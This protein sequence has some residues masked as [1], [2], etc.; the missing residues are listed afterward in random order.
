MI[1]ALAW[2]ESTSLS[3]WVVGSLWAFPVILT[4]HAIGM[5]KLAS[6]VEL[7][8]GGSMLVVVYLAA[9]VSLKVREVSDVWGM[10]RSRLRHAAQPPIGMG[11]QRHGQSGAPV[12]GVAQSHDLARSGI[13]PR[14]HDGGLVGLGAAAGEK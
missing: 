5:G 10:V 3:E 4:L 7:I 8:V 6:V 1:S 13:A 12:I 14:R 2:I 9:A 11:R